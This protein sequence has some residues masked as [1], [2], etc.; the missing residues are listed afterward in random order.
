MFRRPSKKFKS[1][2]NYSTNFYKKF[3]IS[4]AKSRSKKTNKEQYWSW[5]VLNC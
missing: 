4:M 1:R 5:E 3:R 2:K